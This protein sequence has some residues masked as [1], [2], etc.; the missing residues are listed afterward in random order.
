LLYIILSDP[1]YYSYICNNYTK[2]VKFKE[3]DHIIYRVGEEVSKAIITG[4][5][6]EFS[7]HSYTL[8]WNG[9]SDDSFHPINMI[10]SRC[11]L[12][13]SKMR[14]ITMDKLLG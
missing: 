5:L 10:D 4:I 13:I 9:S 7:N 11:E 6:D 12:D 8:R 1:K 3:G 14:K 2:E